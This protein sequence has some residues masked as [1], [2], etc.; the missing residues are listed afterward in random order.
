[1]AQR[2]TTKMMILATINTIKHTI[3]NGNTE[4]GGGRGGR[5]Y[6]TGIA[7]IT[8]TLSKVPKV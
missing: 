1:M 7:A 4:R 3:N 5:K 8:A 2:I 6:I